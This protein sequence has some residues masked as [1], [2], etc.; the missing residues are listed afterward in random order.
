M[1]VFRFPSRAF[2]STDQEVAE[3]CLETHFPGCQPILDEQQWQSYSV[4]SSTEDWLIASIVITEEKTRWANK[5]FVSYKTT[6]E[7]GIL[8][9]KTMERFVD[10]HIK[11]AS[12]KDHPLNPMHQHAHLKNRSTEAALQVEFALGVFLD[13]EGAFANTPFE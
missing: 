1:S 7:D 4:T 9:L 6:G 11:K 5:E 12:L 3:H 8:L 13:V 10:L 2:T